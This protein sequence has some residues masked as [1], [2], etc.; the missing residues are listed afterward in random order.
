MV[1]GEVI[2]N[3][4]VDMICIGEG[5][6][7]IVELANSIEK[8]GID[9]SIQNLWFKKDGGIIKNRVRHLIKDLD[10]LPFPDKLIFC[11]KEQSIRN[12]YAVTSGRGCP[13]SC[14]YCASDVMKRLLTKGETYVRRRS[15]ENVIEE[16]LVAKNSI[17]FNLR[18]INFLDDTFTYD[19]SWLERFCRLYKKEIKLP[20]HCTG[21][22]STVN[23]EKT[24][25]LKDGWII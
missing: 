13:F 19:Y 7:A 5:E 9:Y 23:Y 21:Y 6:E 4:C 25:L 14:T 8:S 17:Y 1:P 11:E 20:F 22:P 12:H 15:P 24:V 3:D 16:L 2:N 18:S 10:K